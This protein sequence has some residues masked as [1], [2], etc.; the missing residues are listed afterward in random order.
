MHRSI[1]LTSRARF[2]PISLLLCLSPFAPPPA[3]AKPS[4]S[5]KRSIIGLRWPLSSVLLAAVNAEP[6]ADG[7]TCVSLR[8]PSGSGSG[9]KPRRLSS[10]EKFASRGSAFWSRRTTSFLREDG[11]SSP[12]GPAG[13]AEA[14]APEVEGTDG[15]GGD[16]LAPLPPLEPPVEAAPPR[17]AGCPP[18]AA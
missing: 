12:S 3:T 2:G 5:I 15:T 14:P 18:P 16:P 7:H 17:A 13:G 8:K 11:S 9:L 4:H 10:A 6:A 1:S